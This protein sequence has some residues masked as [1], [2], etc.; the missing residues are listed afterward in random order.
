MTEFNACNYQT[1]NFT[2][3][4]LNDINLRDGGGG[5]GLGMADQQLVVENDTTVQ[6]SGSS[7]VVSWNH[8]AVFNYC[9]TP[10][11][12]P[13]FGC[14][15][16]HPH[17][18]AVYIHP[19]ITTANSHQADP[20]RVCVNFDVGELR[21]INKVDKDGNIVG[22]NI[23]YSQT[24]ELRKNTPQCSYGKL[25]V[26]YQMTVVTYCNQRYDELVELVSDETGFGEVCHP[27]FVYY[28]RKACP[29]YQVTRF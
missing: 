1:A 16:Q 7:E 9:K 28:T 15:G 6:L 25:K 21:D 8:V 24:D 29:S 4:H 5:K 10:I 23:S 26:D 18:S 3:Y 27:Q 22:F 13:I 2:L 11:K 17:A 12:Q 14:T 20:D 19:H